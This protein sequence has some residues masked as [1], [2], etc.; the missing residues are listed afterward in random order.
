MPQTIKG[1]GQSWLPGE[2]D[3]HP[4]PHRN[5]SASVPQVPALA[6][7]EAGELV[8]GRGKPSTLILAGY[9]STLS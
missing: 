8:E 2:E 9:L 1:I 3:F 4:L 5:C 6:H 7:R